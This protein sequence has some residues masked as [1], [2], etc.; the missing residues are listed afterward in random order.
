MTSASSSEEGM[1]SQ[2]PS[3][4]AVQCTECGRMMFPRH[5]R[6]PGCRKTSFAERAL[7]DGGR[8]LTWTRLTATRPGFAREVYLVVV[9]F[10]DERV[11]V[12]GQFD[13]SGGAPQEGAKVRVT[14]GALSAPEGRAPV[15]GFK[16][17]ADEPGRASR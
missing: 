10:V 14:E 11:R 17:T 5:S 7:R 6:C 3:I 8:I 13:P 9:E 15:L 4:P 2:L 12:L 16:F 1:R